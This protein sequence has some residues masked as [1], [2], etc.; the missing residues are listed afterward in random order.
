M[1]RKLNLAQIERRATQIAERSV[2]AFRQP[3]F[4]PKVLLEVLEI[5]KTTIT[6]WLTRESFDL[7]A[8]KHRKGAG[9][10]LYSARDAILIAA[11]ERLVAVGV[12]FNVAKDVAERICAQLVGTMGRPMAMANSGLH[13]FIF[14]YEGKWRVRP[15]RIGMTEDIPPVRVEFAV[16][17]FIQ[18]V[19]AK[20]GMPV[21]FGTAEELKRAAENTRGKRAT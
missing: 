19:T 3:R 12:E 7:D 10:R 9:H 15:Y 6:N 2:A 4:A 21:I 20:L 1:V 8:N 17:A 11:T 14:K 5:P 13:L 16:D 18:D